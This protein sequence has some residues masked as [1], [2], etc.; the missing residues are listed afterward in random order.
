MHSIQAQMEKSREITYR[1]PEEGVSRALFHHQ[2]IL[3]R[4][5]A[6]DPDGARQAMIQHLEQTKE[7][8]DL[9]IREGRINTML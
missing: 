9:A 3:E 2:N 6:E 5:R 8:L 1:G 4:V 7:D